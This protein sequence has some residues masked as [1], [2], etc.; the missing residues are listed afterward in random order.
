MK[1]TKEERSG[2]VDGRKRASERGVK[3]ERE[4]RIIREREERRT[5][6]KSNH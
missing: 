4:G 5:E 1:K 2:R 3:K 6:K